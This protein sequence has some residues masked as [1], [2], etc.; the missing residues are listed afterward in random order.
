[1]NLAKTGYKANKTK[2]AMN[3]RENYLTLP[4]IIN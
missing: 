4:N 3:L 1:M 2:F